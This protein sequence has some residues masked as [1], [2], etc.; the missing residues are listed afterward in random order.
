MACETE[1]TPAQLKAARTAIYELLGRR[2]PLGAVQVIDRYPAAP[3]TDSTIHLSGRPVR[4]IVRVTVGGSDTTD[5]E[6]YNGFML[7]IGSGCCTGSCGDQ[8]GFPNFFGPNGGNP[9]YGAAYGIGSTVGY[10]DTRYGNCRCWVEIEYIYGF[11]PNEIVTCAINKLAE[12]LCTTCGGVNG[13][14]CGA[15]DNITSVNRQ[16][17]SWQ[18]EEVDAIMDSGGR[19][20]VPEVDKL[21][22]MYNPA[23]AQRRARV[24]S[25]LNPP[26]RRL[27]A[28]RLG[29]SW[30]PGDS[31]YPVGEETG[32]FGD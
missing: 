18:I 20:G 24:F 15:P 8:R 6:L 4:E 23:R 25:Y 7:R 9:N 16:G 26:P 28:V 17:M 5:Y 31:P 32:G 10:P 11:P 21:L 12:S 1:A 30:T 27:M 29:D 19:T 22:A 13:C 2:N 14:A 3:S